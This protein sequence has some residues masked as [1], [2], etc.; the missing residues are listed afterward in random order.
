MTEATFPQCRIVTERLLNPDTTERLLNKVVSVAGVRRMVLNGP[1]L[2]LTV[3]YGPSKGIDNPHPMR[4]T[5]RVGDQEIPLQVHVG[6]VL[7]EIESRDVIP[8][9]KAAI[10]PVF[11]DF[12]FYIQEGRYM[13]TE[14]SLV[15]YCKYGPNADKEM[16]GL[17]DPSSKSKPI[18]LQGIK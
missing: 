5:I 15:D 1:R 12:T 13:K 9:L 18:I 8:A 17:S 4:K 10:E 7:L 14:P 16:L 2:P 3:P 6:T 11:P